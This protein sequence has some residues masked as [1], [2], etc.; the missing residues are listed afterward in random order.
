MEAELLAECDEDQ[1]KV[2]LFFQRV[3][4]AYP[5]AY[6]CCGE[7]RLQVLGRI[8]CVRLKE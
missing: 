1:G 6:T 8:L 3:I 5:T 7:I 4:E 2:S